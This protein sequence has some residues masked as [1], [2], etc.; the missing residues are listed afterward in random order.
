MKLLLSAYA[1]APGKG[2]E[3]EVGL[4]TV[5]AAAERH[6]VWVLTTRPMA[7]ATERFLA[8]HPAA[9]RI[10]LEAVDPP[11]PG[12]A[13]G[14]RMLAR[15]Q[16]HYD[17]W[18]RHA[19]AR[20]V[21]LDRRVGFDVVHHVTL[22]AYWMRVGG[23]TVGKPL[24]W[25]PIGGAVE[26]PIRLLSELGAR[27]LVE[28]ALRTGMRLA[29]GSVWVRRA[30]GHATVALAQNAA[31][32]ARL[33]R[34]LDG[35]VTV[36]SHAI[37][38]DIAAVPTVGSRTK[39]IVFVGRLVPW[40]AA[41][42]A[43]RTMLHVRDPGAMLVIYGDGADRDRVLAAARRLG[44]ADRVRLAGMAPRDEVLA[45]IA[46]AGALLHPALH[47]EGG[48]AV[49]EALS[50]GAPLVCLDH[51]GPAEL[52]RQWSRAPSA[53]I[54]PSWPEKTARALAEAVDRF[55]AHPPPIPTAV[56]RPQDR[57]TARILDAYD[58][59]LALVSPESAQGRRFSP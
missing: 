51:G 23:A 57:Y 42:L 59:A 7:E 38:V 26:P 14:V 17:R 3:P 54:P 6:D 56:I 48:I 31:T 20:G 43:V 32:A 19:G 46:R 13:S 15:N 47:E 21:E 1:C 39:E 45:A 34:L 10:H 4:R 22:A 30:G 18:Q 44:V 52:I 5:L 58:Q 9:H 2:S 11:H 24:V 50:M 16:W 25:G 35:R 33:R 40:K 28:S 8:G 41:R 37:A 27:G 36:M 12:P 53:A 49:A 29:A 55:L